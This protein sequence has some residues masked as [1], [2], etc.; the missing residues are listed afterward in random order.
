MVEIL[1]II[2]SVVLLVSIGPLIQWWK[3]KY[4]KKKR[5]VPVYVFSKEL[6]DGNLESLKCESF[7]DSKV[8]GSDLNIRGSVRL[9]HNRILTER[10]FEE[11]KVKASSIELP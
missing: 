1:I 7:G 3:Y 5:I 8:N 11:R 6:L 9:S 4:R 10:D 2:V